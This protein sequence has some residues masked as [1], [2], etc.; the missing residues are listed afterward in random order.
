[1][2]ALAGELLQGC[3]MVSI[4]ALLLRSFASLSAFSAP[5]ARQTARGDR[6]NTPSQLLRLFQQASYIRFCLVGP[7]AGARACARQQPTRG[8]SA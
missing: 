7:T 1:M 6:P 3:L 8:A 5:L 2:I 4:T